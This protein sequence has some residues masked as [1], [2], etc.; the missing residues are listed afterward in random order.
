MVATEEINEVKSKA[1]FILITTFSTTWR[2]AHDLGGKNSGS[3]R[4]VH[5]RICYLTPIAHRERYRPSRVIFEVNYK[6]WQLRLQRYQ[7]RVTRNNGCIR[8]PNK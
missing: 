4:L 8:V 5:F 2:T 1:P 7:R 6:G 3:Q